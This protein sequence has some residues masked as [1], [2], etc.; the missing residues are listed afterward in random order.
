MAKMFEEIEVWQL[1]RNLIK[2]IFKLTS[3]GNIGRNYCI[4]D[5]MQ[6]AALSVMNNT[7]LT[8]GR[9][10]KVLKDNQIGNLSIF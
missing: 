9:F 2:E 1:S 3:S 6:R 4:T 8:A 5:Q 7:C 10:L